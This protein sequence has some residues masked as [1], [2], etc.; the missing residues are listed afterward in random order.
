[1]SEILLGSDPKLRFLGHTSGNVRS[2][3]DYITNAFADII[4]DESAKNLFLEV[5]SNR[6]IP[7]LVSYL[8]YDSTS[9]RG[10]RILHR[11]AVHQGLHEGC[12]HVCDCDLLEHFNIADVSFMDPRVR[13]WANFSVRE[14]GWKVVVLTM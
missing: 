1:M 10:Q 7:S 2:V 6:R 14:K 11:F 9:G 3:C 5:V 13:H 4:Q 8:V 12:L